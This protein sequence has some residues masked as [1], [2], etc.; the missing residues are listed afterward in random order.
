MIFIKI[1][2]IGAGKVGCTL[3]KF[4]K[5]GG[6]SISGYYSRTAT[7]AKEAA[8]FT[9][10]DTFKTISQLIRESDAVF[11][12]VPDGKIKS[13][14]N[15][16][17]QH[18]IEGKIICHAS[19]SLTV[20]EC[21]PD[22]ESK[23]AY[24]YSIH[25]LF[26]V[27]TKFKTYKELGGAFFCIEGSKKYLKN[28]TDILENL[29][30]NARIIQGSDKVKYHAACAISS[31]LMCALVGESIDLLIECGFPQDMALKALTPLIIS[32]LQHITE[33]GPVK[34]LTGPV[35]RGDTETVRKH[36]TCFNKEEE[37]E[38]YRYLT[39]K[40]IDIAK[41]KHMDRDY[42]SIENLINE[43]P[44]TYKL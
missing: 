41:E 3:G 39:L 36:L 43:T 1:G 34:A 29:G 4:L 21:F 31:N 22:I 17:S 12:T 5:E 42:S 2:F 8:D 26:P 35:E 37:R 19:G 40:L 23:G 44:T 15:Q 9:E 14:Y 7:S 11:I 33:D 27:S 20:A 25:P 13:V 10:S 18:N 32:N 24:G 38:M 16:V 6:Y 30:C 28:I